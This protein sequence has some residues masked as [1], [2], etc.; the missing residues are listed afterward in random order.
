V[1][2]Q[3]MSE[4]NFTAFSE[5]MPHEHRWLL[6]TNNLNAINTHGEMSHLWLV[7]SVHQGSEPWQGLVAYPSLDGAVVTRLT[8]W[9]YVFEAA[10]CPRFPTVDGAA[11][12]PEVGRLRDENL[13][14]VLPK[15]GESES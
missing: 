4:Y 2:K 7:H 3:A 10:K 13:R 5:S 1:K 8:H 12:C 11:H 15:L 14:R 6:V 9:K